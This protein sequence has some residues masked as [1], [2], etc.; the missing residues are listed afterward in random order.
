MIY[1]DLSTIRMA[2]ISLHCIGSEI[3][4]KPFLGTAKYWWTDG[5]FFLGRFL[6]KSCCNF[7]LKNI[8]AW[9]TCN[10]LPTTD[11]TCCRRLA[12]VHSFQRRRRRHRFNSATIAAD[13]CLRRISRP[14]FTQFLISLALSLSAFAPFSQVP[15]IVHVQDNQVHEFQHLQH[16]EL[17]PCTAHHNECSRGAYS[18]R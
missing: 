16:R 3:T 13:I 9:P 10:E 4:V 2:F 17:W 14:P 18:I 15:P 1:A 7:L 8:S 11:D 6:G 5:V 12:T